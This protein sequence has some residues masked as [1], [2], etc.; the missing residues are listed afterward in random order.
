[1]GVDVGL[2]VGAVATGELQAAAQNSA[3]AATKRRDDET[4]IAGTLSRG[5][6]WLLD[7]S[8][9]IRDMCIMTNGYTRRLAA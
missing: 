4:I 5:R 2:L 6:A 7:S 3:S 9:C 1:M 8:Q